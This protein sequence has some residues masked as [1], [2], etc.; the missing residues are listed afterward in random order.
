MFLT[1]VPKELLEEMEAALSGIVEVLD[2][3]RTVLKD[4]PEIV[5]KRDESGK[6]VEIE[7][8]GA[9]KHNAK[10]ERD[11]YL[12]KAFKAQKHPCPLCRQVIKFTGGGVGA[13]CWV[14]CRCGAYSPMRATW[15]ACMDP[16]GWRFFNSNM[17]VRELMKDV[18]VFDTV[19]DT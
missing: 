4:N 1:L 8:P 14:E 18:L 7:L 6:I 16:N 19:P 9:M 5:I 15:K 2:Y 3:H 11:I 13:C 17:I 10:V 12:S